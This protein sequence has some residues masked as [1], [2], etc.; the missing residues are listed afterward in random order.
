MHIKKTEI[1]YVKVK[2]KSGA[3]S[4]ALSDSPSFA[5]KISVFFMCIHQR[6]D[7]FCIFVFGRDIPDVVALCIC[8]VAV[9]RISIIITPARFCADSCAVTS[10]LLDF[11]RPA[12]VNATSVVIEHKINSKQ[13]W[14]ST[15]SC[16]PRTLSAPAILFTLHDSIIH[17]AHSKKSQKT[18]SILCSPNA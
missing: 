13:G 17:N 1:S 16:S 12:F 18:K 10:L 7:F 5:F 6:L 3:E 2:G 11:N 8:S 9:L 15:A 14:K 4:Q